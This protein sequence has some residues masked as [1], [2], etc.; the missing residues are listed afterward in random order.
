[1]SWA[2]RDR[3][4]DEPEEANGCKREEG[5]GDDRGRRIFV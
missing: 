2:S 5:G 4:V 3:C 1:M